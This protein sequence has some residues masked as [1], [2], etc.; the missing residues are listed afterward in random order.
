MSWIALDDAARVLEMMGSASEFSGVVNV[1][2]PEP[3]TNAH[4]TKRYAALLGRHAR[5]VVPKVALTAAAGRRVTEEFLLQSA[6]VRPERLL[7][8]GF[9]YRYPDLD[10]ALRAA[11]EA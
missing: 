3:V 1:V 10:G 7:E 4:F 11:I 5:L 9:P 2:A 8:A 6:R